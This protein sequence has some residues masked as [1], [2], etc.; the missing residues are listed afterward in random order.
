MGGMK[1]VRA[2]QHQHL[3]FLAQ[4]NESPTKKFDGDFDTIFDETGHE[5][6]P[7]DERECP[8][9]TSQKQDKV[10]HTDMDSRLAPSSDVFE[11]LT[12]GLLL[13]GVHNGR[14]VEEP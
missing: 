7:G 14:D 1:E 9:M 5:Q 6:G 8:P 4:Y 3:E 12:T 11:T 2:L 10:I 13:P